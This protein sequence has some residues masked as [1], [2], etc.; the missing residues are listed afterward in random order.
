[1]DSSELHLFLRLLRAEA[2]L[3]TDDLAG[4]DVGLEIARVCDQH[5]GADRVAKWLD[6]MQRRRAAREPLIRPRFLA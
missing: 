4:K 3:P 5:F 6:E 2:E 1:M